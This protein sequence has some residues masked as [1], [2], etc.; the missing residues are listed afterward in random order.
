MSPVTARTVADDYVAALTELDPS[1]ATALGVRSDRMPDLSPAGL[2]AR[3]DLARRTLAALGS[4]ATDT[5]ADRRCARLLSE[6]LTAQL[7]VHD[8]G[9]DLRSLRP[10]GSPLQGLRSIFLMMPTATPQDWADIAHRLAEVPRAA[11][12]YR[13]TLAE[14]IAQ[15]MLSAPRQVASAVAQLEAWLEADW[16]A[17]FVAAGPDAL[18]T[19]L[20]DAAAAAAV[21]LGELRAWLAADYAAA[22]EG[23]PDA[24]GR[25]RY[26]LAARSTTGARVDPEEAYAWGW[27]EL[28]RIEAEMVA[29][30]AQVLPGKSVGAVL[31]HLGTHGPAIE[32]EEAVRRHLQDLMDTAITELDGTLVDIPE[33]VRTV[34]ARIAPPGS[35]AAPYYT[36]PSLDFARPGRTWLPTLGRD[37]FPLW[38]L[39]STWYHEGV[40][41]HHL[42]LAM[43]VHLAPQLSRY[44]VS[45]GSVSATTEGWALYAERLMDER[46]Y[47]TDPAERLGY[48]DA[49]RMRAVR[50]IIDIG[51][52]LELEV[53]A[54]DPIA[55]AFLAD[56]GL[57]AGARWTPALA[58]EFFGRHCGREDDFLDSEIDRYL[59][60]PGQAIS[61]KLGERA[62]LAGRAAAQERATAAGRAWDAKAWHTAALGLGSLGLDD[63]ERELTDL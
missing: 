18:R 5:D 53:P 57:E 31:A 23:T 29:E 55:A 39:V 11:E 26:L 10:I 54:A 35:A 21:A 46:G 32:G 7:D 58:R 33:P 12:D 63:L 2:A 1:V 60:W 15:G 51:M 47:L 27:A 3:A 6:R 14:G 16:Y 43:W 9:E 62:W 28:G 8:A 20:D 36:R 37:R 25:E 41:G 44:Q 45:I 4:A 56:A 40:P 50:I 61:Y 42:Q 52:H 24:V 38:D 59:G 48:L 19:E 30:A 17:E 34:E 13:A 22:A 49:Q